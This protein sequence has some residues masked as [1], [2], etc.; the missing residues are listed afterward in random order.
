MPLSD[1]IRRFCP[2]VL[3]IKQRA[4]LNFALVLISPLMAAV[5]L[6]SFKVLFDEIL[7]AGRLDLLSTFAAIYA[8]AAGAKIAVDYAAQSI[9]ASNI[10][11]IV[12]AL[13]SDAYA[14]VMSLS[15][16]SLNKITSG[17]VLTRLQGDT[18]R[19]ETL[20]YT[21]PLLAFS[22]AAAV[23]I[24]FCFLTYLNWQLTLCALAAL[25]VVVWIVNRISPLVRKASQLSRRADSHWMSLA[26]ERLNAVP[27][28][29]AFS[30]EDREVS[31]FLQR[32]AKVKRM[33]VASLVLQARQSA[34]VELVVATAGLV[35]V[36]FGALLIRSGVMTIGELVTFIGT[37]GSLYAPVRSLAKAAG[38]FQN[39]AAGAQRI[40]DLMAVPSL[41]ADKPNAK[42]LEKARGAIAFRNVHF[43]YPN[44]Q[45]VLHGVSFKIEPGETVALVGPSGSGKTSLARLLLRQSDVNAGAVFVDGMDV[46]DITRASLRRTIAPVFQDAMILNGTIEKNI[47]YGAPGAPPAEVAVAAR[48][49]A[50]DSFA[51]SKGGLLTPVGPGGIKLSGGQRQRVALARAL[52]CKSPILLLDEATAGLDG[53]TEELI[54]DALEKLA[55]RRTILVVAHRLSSVWRAD[56]V[57]VLEDGRIVE[58]GKP[59]ELL[60]K[61]SRCRELFSAQLVERVAA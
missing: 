14:H 21:A 37:V 30:A 15:P 49:A 33:E 56:R 13:R 3:A 9:E 59:T 11:T 26:E 29:H 46:R 31:S 40:A 43:A 53:E 57:I 60:S 5:L 6:W 4:L 2:Y 52:L 10:E 58:T 25:P 32:C 45:K 8:V 36:G 42:V 54:Q 17:D 47:R 48:A 55:G 24:Y 44:G 41:V 38:R 35:V 51:F 23:V 34:L 19:A 1:L 61:S 7:V 16:G 50:V 28:V 27:V 22:D 12:L 39:S 18:I 20:I